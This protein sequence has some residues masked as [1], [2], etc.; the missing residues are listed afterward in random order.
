MG[1]RFSVTLNSTETP[2]GLRAQGEFSDSETSVL[3]RFRAYA[4]DLATAALLEPPL[5]TLSVVFGTGGAIE[6]HNLPPRI[7]VRELLHLIRPLILT[8]EATSFYTV[9]SIVRQQLPA[10]PYQRM[11]ERWK[12]RFSGKE[13]K[14]VMRWEVG[15]RLVNSEAT[16]LLWL[17]AFEYHRDEDK[18]AI[19][20][21]LGKTMSF[22][23]LEGIFLGL[24]MDKCEAIA[25]LA[26]F[27][28]YMESSPTGSAS[29]AAS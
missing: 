6:E 16:L 13:Q 2:E 24:I 29:L 17:N 27:I 23:L 22:E 18:R 28:R 11:F 12:R 8:S 1:L 9:L 7:K 5:W 25:L 19:V 26:K 3:Q 21:D 4:D 10:E 14:E 15:G 20:A